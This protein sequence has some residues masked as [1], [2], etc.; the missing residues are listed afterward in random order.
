VS[1]RVTI[2]Q[3]DRFYV[4]EE[5]VRIGTLKE[6]AEIPYQTKEHCHPSCRFANQQGRFCSTCPGKDARIIMWSRETTPAGRKL[7]AIASGSSK[8][9]DRVIR[10]EYTIVDR[11]ADPPFRHDLQWTGKLR[12]GLV[13][14]G[15]NT[16]DQKGMLGK[17]RAK[18]RDGENGG[19]IISPPRSGKC[20]YPD[21]M[22]RT[23][24][25][26]H[27]ISECLAGRSQ[28]VEVEEI[29]NF[30]VVSTPTGNHKIRGIYANTVDRTVEITLTGNVVLGGSAVHPIAVD[31]IDE[32]G[33]N[34]KR[35][36]KKLGTLGGDEL[37]SVGR[38]T[39]DP[40][41]A[42][43][44]LN[45]E[46]AV[47]VAMIL[48][49][50]DDSKFQTGVV[51]ISA[52]SLVNNNALMVL[53][54]KY[55]KLHVNGDRNFMGMVDNMPIVKD[56]KHL[57]MMS[58]STTW[59]AFIDA[60]VMEDAEHAGARL[61]DRDVARALQMHLL[62]QGVMASINPDDDAAIHYVEI[63]DL[64]AYDIYLHPEH[65]EEKLPPLSLQ[66]VSIRT[67]MV[68]RRVMDI[69]VPSCKCFFSNGLISHNTV[70]GVAASMSERSRTFITASKIDFLRQ[71]GMR[72]GELTNLRELYRRGK[73][74]VILIDPKGWPDGPLHGVHVLKKWTP[75][76]RRADVVMST[77]Q[78][79][80]NTENGNARKRKYLDGQF[81]TFI[82]DEIHMAAAK[83]F[84]RLCNRLDSRRKL[85]LTAT[86][87]RKDKTEAV[88]Y[89]SLGPVVAKGNA[90]SDLP[91]VS[92]L[93]TGIGVGRKYNNW[94]AMTS[95][96]I[97][98]KER[99]KIIVRRVFKILR[100]NRQHCV[101]ITTTRREH[102]EMLV[103]MINAQGQFCNQHRDE[104][105]PNNIAVPYMGGKDTAAI[106]NLTNAGKARVVVAMTS[107]VQYGLDIARW[108]HVF[109]GVVP[110]SNPYNTY[111]LI[112]RV[113][114]PYKPELEKK[115]GVKPQSHAIVCVDALSASIF[116]FVKIFKDPDF[117]IAAGSSKAN[118]FGVPLYDMLDEAKA[119]MTSIAK[120]P[121]EYDPADIGVKTELGTT[122]TGKKRK[123][124]LWKK[125]P[126]GITRL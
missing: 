89:R 93:E 122:A 47:M 57:L 41:P 76:V 99:N 68:P 56:W 74:P 55:C 5:A 37:I 12:T 33:N 123:K 70:I 115:L 118:Y 120:Y 9:L 61:P 24:M 78:Q 88:V 4:P 42:G 59:K 52:E 11:R 83:M 28:R 23:N 121:R 71:F 82:G 94:A 58:S 125:R 102:V 17:W 106:I 38:E 54:S 79:F 103:K 30:G 45:V 26:Y 50:C 8:I 46:Q 2:V 114:T 126:E 31:E 92:L 29:G 77:Y 18:I 97:R 62:Q 69:M 108:T 91:L 35:I 111:Q 20:V 3:R 84:N 16:A 14:N 15:R 49:L 43:Q 113:C 85:G 72:F 98:M 19:I 109:I 110:T 63:V 34:H 104:D 117:G 10:G 53:L 95:F 116:S 96:L 25:G 100:E 87:K 66:I 7:V 1:E 22:I 112:N 80:M 27:H 73:T 40:V 32:S 36:W 86:I 51:S 105:W 107:M 81:G 67:L 101:L 21:T 64:E 44:G 48:V 90:A 65:A 124:S 75:E 119:R 13:V 6:L 39:E 60:V